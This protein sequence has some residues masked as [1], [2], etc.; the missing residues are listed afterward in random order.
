[1][2]KRRAKLNHHDFSGIFIGYAPTDDN[3]RYIDVESGV[4]K[5]PH[6]AV[7]NEAWYLQPTRPPAAQLLYDMGME[8]DTDPTDDDHLPHN[9]APYPPLS[10]KA[11]HK[12]PTKAR[13]YPIP[14]RISQQPDLPVYAASA[15]KTTALP[16]ESQQCNCGIIEHESKEDVF[17]QIYLSPTPYHDAFEE[18]LDL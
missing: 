12:L 4:V 3:I 7:F 9:L 10:A 6:H 15:A 16:H 11:P 5:T 1:M 2:G 17:R 13:I 14:F 8:P 18:N